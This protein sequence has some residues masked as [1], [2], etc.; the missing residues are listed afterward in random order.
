M[1]SWHA[2]SFCSGSKYLSS[3]SCQLWN[4]FYSTECSK[5][6]YGER[7]GYTNGCPKCPA[8]SGTKHSPGR[9]ALSLKDCFC[10]IGFTGNPGFGIPCTRKFC[11]VEGKVQLSFTEW[12]TFAQ[13][14]LNYFKARLKVRH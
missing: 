13:K 10:N 6:T 4:F 3:I 5:D 8:N 12:W 11:Y 2:I 1:I 7:R 9:P 14:E